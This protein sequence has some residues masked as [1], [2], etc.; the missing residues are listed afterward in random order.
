M[1]VSCEASLVS[2]GFDTKA[3]TRSTAATLRRVKLLAMATVS[4]RSASHIHTAYFSFSE[5]LEFYFVSDIST[6]HVKNL[7]REPQAAVAIYESGQAWDSYHRGLQLFGPCWRATKAEA[8]IAE[9]IHSTRFPAYAEYVTGLGTRER[10]LSPH[11][12][13]VFR[14]DIIKIYDER[15]F[16]EEVFATATV[17]RRP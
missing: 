14:P 4:S 2:V 1:R 7:M 17:T 11:K 9:R 15:A 16:G 13:H 5:A 8:A 12:F 10:R 6:E 3:I